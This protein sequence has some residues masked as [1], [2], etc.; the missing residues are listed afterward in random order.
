MKVYTTPLK[1][2]VLLLL[3]LPFHIFATHNRAGEI[4]VEYVDGLTCRATIITY[5]KT[6]SVPADRKELVIK[7]GDGKLD[8]VQRRNNNGE[9]L[10]KDIKKNIYTFTHRYEKYGEYV[11]SMLD[12]N[13][14]SG[15]LNVNFPQS[16]AIPFYI[17]TTITLSP[18]LKNSTPRLL[19][20]PIDRGMVGIPFKHI[21]NAFDAEDDSIAY[22]LATPLQ[23]FNSPVPLYEYPNRIKPGLNNKITLNEKTGEFTWI[24][25]QQR[26]E[27][28]I[29]ILI[30]SYRKGVVIDYTLRDM[31][32]LIEEA[33]VATAS[34]P[35]ISTPVPLLTEVKAGQE[36][37]LILKSKIGQSPEGVNGVK[38]YK[39]TA[40]SGAFEVPNN[41]AEFNNKKGYQAA[42]SDT[43]RWKITEQ[44]ARKL[45]YM[46]VFKIEDN[47]FDSTG[48]VN[49]YVLEIKVNSLSSKIEE[50]D[51]QALT[52]Y[53][54]PSQDAVTLNF[55]KENETVLLHVFDVTGRTV[56]STSVKN[57]NVFSLKKEEIGKGVFFV[58]SYFEKSNTVAVKKIVFQ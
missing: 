23:D 16:D 9:L 36:V 32:I 33:T 8:T 25:P 38:S 11:I 4:H 55:E 19:N 37:F 41:K 24:S 29:A 6:S 52:A 50:F 53:P 56:F 28:G 15:V 22:R 13:R 20:P 54:N 2:L 7:W 57:Q 12:P 58:R 10:P 1:A 31:Q 34:L 48:L 39:I 21:V 47:T 49:F 5:T 14:N 18:I 26:G 17:H 51:N 44:H 3:A 46:V 40:T 43:F 45:P 27:Y 30:I 42:V 35:E